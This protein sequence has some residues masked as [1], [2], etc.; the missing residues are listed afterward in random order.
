MLSEKGGA[1]LGR[2]MY[3]TKSTEFD[4]R[5]RE[6]PG[7]PAGAGNPGNVLYIYLLDPPF[8]HLHQPKKA[9][10]KHSMVPLFI[11][12]MQRTSPITAATTY[13][14]QDNP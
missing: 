14:V 11:S 9:I 5:A 3:R 1:E 6:I 12:F 7:D 4:P 13:P 8:R 2:G 10:T